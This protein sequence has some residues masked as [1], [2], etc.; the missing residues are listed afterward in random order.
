MNMTK[1]NHE[2]ALQ[3]LVQIAD[4]LDKEPAELTSEM[5]DILSAISVKHGAAPVDDN[6][7]DLWNMFE[8][9]REHAKN[10][11]RTVVGEDRPHQLRLAWRCT[12]TNKTWSIRIANFK[13][14][15]NNTTPD[16][17][18]MVSRATQTQEG[19]LNLTAALNSKE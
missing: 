2:E 17:K 18:E 16:K 7:D 9:I 13:K 3:K 14:S 12:N 8:D 10:N 1:L 19:R 4:A 15:L 5:S 6:W 11:G